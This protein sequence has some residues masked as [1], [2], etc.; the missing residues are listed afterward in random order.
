MG[1]PK[2]SRRKYE[3]PRHPW[4]GARIKDEAELLKKYGLKNKRELWK[5][6]S[7]LREFRQRARIL[8]AQ[9]RY[10]EKQAEKEKKELISKLA[11]IGLLKENA[12]LDDVLALDVD[13]VL[14]RRLQSITLKKGLAYSHLQARQLI[15]HGHISVEGRKVTIPSYLV[16]KHEEESLEYNP[17]S[18]LMN[19]MHPAR[20]TPEAQM[21]IKQAEE[22]GQ[23][24]KMGEK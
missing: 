22:S 12:N 20:P 5:A 2:F 10:G 6:K 21:Q 16:K 11:R 18:P 8:Q 4:E 14:R 3:G 24:E 1:D 15:V 23:S 17:S 13:S 9:V 19:E 7:L